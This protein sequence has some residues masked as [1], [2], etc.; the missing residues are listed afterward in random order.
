MGNQ[1]PNRM[2]GWSSP[3]MDGLSIATHDARP[4]LPRLEILFGQ[5]A[6]QRA[7]LDAEDFCGLGSV[8]TGVT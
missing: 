1:R 6:D 8:V 7:A 2:A 4:V 5:S 3:N